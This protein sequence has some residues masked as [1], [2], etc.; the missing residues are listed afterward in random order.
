[1]VRCGMWIEQALSCTRSPVLYCERPARLTALIPLRAQRCGGGGRRGWGA[2]FL[3]CCA[4]LVLCCAVLCCAM[5]LVGWAG[6][7]M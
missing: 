7:G 3:A 5:R 4:V 1:M 6:C 2:C